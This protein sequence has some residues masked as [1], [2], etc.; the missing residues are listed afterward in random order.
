MEVRAA[1]FLTQ[2]DSAT[3]LPRKKALEVGQW[4]RAVARGVARG[5]EAEE[6]VAEAKGATVP[7]EQVH[8]RLI[9]S[10]VA[11]AAL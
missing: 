1:R 8:S 6:L 7:S 10:S 5:P 3:H 11:V 4:H 9:P 2:L